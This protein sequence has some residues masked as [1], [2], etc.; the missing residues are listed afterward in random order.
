MLPVDWTVEAVMAAVLGVLAAALRMAIRFSLSPE[1]RAI[2]RVL[3]EAGAKA[4]LRARAALAQGVKEARA[5]DSEGGAAITPAER[6]RLA[7]D[8]VRAFTDEL[9][10][11]GVLERVA[12]A[13]GGVEKL[14]AELIRRVEHTLD[15]AA[16]TRAK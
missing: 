11:L 10:V 15:S 8:A 5:A 14:E 16:T 6:Q 2:L 4:A 12:Q 1:G 7:R 3:R 9:D 13:F